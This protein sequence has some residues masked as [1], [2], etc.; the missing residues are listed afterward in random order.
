[1]MSNRV[2]KVVME[3]GNFIGVRLVGG[4]GGILNPFHPI[5]LNVLILL[6]SRAFV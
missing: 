2:N 3:A 1:M 6:H 5:P 4:E